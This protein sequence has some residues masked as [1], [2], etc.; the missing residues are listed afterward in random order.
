MDPSNEHSMAKAPPKVTIRALGIEGARHLVSM[1]H[2][3]GWNPG[4]YDAETFFRVDP[5]AFLGVFA[6]ETYAGG[7]AIARHSEAFGFMGLFIVRPELRGQ[8]IGRKLWYERRNRLFARLSEG[9]TIGLDGVTAMVPFYAEGGFVPAYVSHHFEL[10]EGIAAME[11]NPYVRPLSD[12]EPKAV[13]ALDRRAFP[14]DRPA[15]R[16]AWLDQPEA[17]V[18]GFGPSPD[19]LEGFGVGRPAA[20]GTKIG[21]LFAEN[22]DAAKA[23]LIALSLDVVAPVSISIPE[24]NPAAIAMAESLGMRELFACTRMYFGPRPAYEADLIYG[25]TSFELG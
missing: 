12:F 16:A 13:E 23:L 21:P 11:P 20:S 25:L 2:D 9:A 15:Y 8:G 1:A 5:E 19:R 22:P 7:G 24:A 3:E 6:D 18:L 10:S 17:T 4:R 14:T